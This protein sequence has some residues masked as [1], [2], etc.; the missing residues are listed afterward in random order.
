M[1]ILGFRYGGF[2]KYLKWGYPQSS[3]ILDWERLGCSMINHPAIGVPPW[4]WKSRDQV[5]YGS[6][7]RHLPGGTRE[8]RVYLVDLAG[9]R[10]AQTRINYWRLKGNAIMIYVRATSSV[11]CSF[12]LV[13]L[14]LLF[15]MV[16]SAFLLVIWWYEPLLCWSN[17]FNHILSVKFSFLKSVFVGSIT[18]FV[19]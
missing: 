2:L 12:N 9:R 14:K 17:C 3:S 13:S 1:V 8:T 11:G 7:L 18:T 15:F 5:S 4:L 16:S 6:R 19:A 10:A